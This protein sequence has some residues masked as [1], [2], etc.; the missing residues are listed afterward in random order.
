[1]PTR[2]QL[3]RAALLRA[4]S[5]AMLTDLDALD[6]YGVT[7][8]PADRFVRVL[9]AND[10][11]RSSR[12][13]MVLCRTKRL[14]VPRV[15]SAMPVAPPDRSLA[16]FLLRHGDD[17]EALAI[18]A[19]AV[20]RKVCSVEGLSFEA[21]HGPARGRPRLVRVINALS[22]GVRSLPENDFRELVRRSRVLPE[23]LW[24]SL[25]RLPNGVVLSPDALFEDA[26]VVHETNGRRHHAADDDFEDMQRRH[27]QMVAA[28]LVPLHNSPRRIDREGRE[29]IQEVEACYLRH[30]GRGLPRGIEI[31]RRGAA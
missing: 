26:G 11:R 14:P 22:T 3:R 18:A 6:L 5:T 24:N 25:L 9:I 4:G 19:A 29:V 15:V 17:R 20:Q 28:G 31:L 2:R 12:D 7:G 1:M 13:F 10:V 30:K 8:L 23:P 27:D 16:D 21:E